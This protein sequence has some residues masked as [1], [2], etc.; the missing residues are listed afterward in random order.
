MNYIHNVSSYLSICLIHML[1]LLSH[2]RLFLPSD[3]FPTGLVTKIE[4][5]FLFAPRRAILHDR[6]C[7]SFHQSSYIWRRIQIIEGPYYPDFSKLLP[8]HLFCSKYSLQHLVPNVVSLRSSLNF[9]H[10]VLQLYRTANKF[11]LSYFKFLRF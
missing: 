6:H 10:Q 7:L 8:F 11:T 9:R 3:V 4:S 5:T 1:I 2:P